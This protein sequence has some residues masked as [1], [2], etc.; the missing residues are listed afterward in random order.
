MGFK[1]RNNSNKVESE[2]VVYLLFKDYCWLTKLA[3]LL[4]IPVKFDSGVE[5][6][7]SIGSGFKIWLGLLMQELNF[8]MFRFVETSF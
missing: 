2:L 6:S 4:E 3:V 1:L 7:L 5:C 8:F